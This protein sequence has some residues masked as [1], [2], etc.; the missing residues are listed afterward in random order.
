MTMKFL[1]SA[2]LLALPG[3]MVASDNSTIPFGNGAWVYDGT[4]DSFGS[5]LAPKAGLFVDNLTAYNNMATD[6]HRIDQPFAYGGDI[7]MYCQGSGETSVGDTCSPN[8]FLITLYPASQVSKS[9]NK[10]DYFPAKLGDSGFASLEQYKQVPNTKNH[11]I[12][13]D[14]RLDNTITGTYDYLDHLN[15]LNATDAQ[16]FADKVAYSICADD[17]IRGTQ[18]DVEPFSFAGEGGSFPVTDTSKKGQEFFYQQIAKDFAGYHSGDPS[19]DPFHCVDKKN[20]NG[21]F[22]SVF[23]FSKSIT[24]EVA[25]TLTKY[26]N[27]MVVDSLYDLGS[28]PGGTVNSVAEFRAFAVAEIA[29]MKALANRYGLAYQF[30]IPAAASAHEFESKSGVSTGYKQIDYVKAAIG[31]IQPDQLKQS[32]PNF[33]GVDV[34]SWNKAMWWGG[35]QFTPAKPSD[36]VLNYLKD[37]L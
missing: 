27:G 9:K 4:Y 32:D 5:K 2:L 1:S 23:T 10:W 11:V 8:S 19:K 14:G 25:K 33:K 36:D 6:G 37:T 12:V 34:W 21:R 31:A 16:N 29:A 35:N 18:F 30:A 20:P 15:T 13:I 22:F 28:K 26:H 3:L 7:E 17:S 24:S